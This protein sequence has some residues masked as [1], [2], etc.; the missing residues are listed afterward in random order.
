[1]KTLETSFDELEWF[2]ELGDEAEWEG[3]APFTYDKVPRVVE[4][5]LS[6]GEVE[7]ALDEIIRRGETNEN[8]LSDLVFFKRHPERNGRYISQEDK[9][10]KALS[11]EWLQIRD[12]LVRQALARAGQAPPGYSRQCYP[13]TTNRAPAPIVRLGVFYSGNLPRENFGELL[14]AVAD[15]GVTDLYF[16]I[17]YQKGEVTEKRKCS[18]V[19]PSPQFSTAA[20]LERMNTAAVLASDFCRVGVDVHLMTWLWPTDSYLLDAASVL[21]GV[22]ERAPIRSLLFDVEDCWGDVS[23]NES[24]ARAL[25]Q[26]AWRFDNWPCELGA[27][28]TTAVRTTIRPVIERCDYV[29][30]QAYSYDEPQRVYDPGVTQQT[31]HQNWK[32]F[33]KRMVMGLAA[34]N[35]KR[36]IIQEKGSAAPRPRKPISVTEA[37]KR[38]IVTTQNLQNPTVREVAYWVYSAIRH[39]R[40]TEHLA[41]VLQAARKARAGVSQA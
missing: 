2:D 21:R 31:A 37:L 4:Y 11:Q 22:C 8:Y 15:L 39:P 14:K 35:L 1:M 33:G 26:R 29:L 3:E 12:T 36:P 6:V 38:A 30:P 5:L 28:S 13:G 9:D 27:T 7:R 41:F 18:Q 24:N 25:V 23:G 17:N 16:E 20:T 10:Y 34:H 32:G 19:A 40:N